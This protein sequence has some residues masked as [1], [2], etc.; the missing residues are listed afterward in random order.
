MIAVVKAQVS[1]TALNGRR[2]MDRDVAAEAQMV[3]RCMWIVIGWPCSLPRWPA[4]SR[5]S[6]CAGWSWPWRR[7]HYSRVFMTRAFLEAASSCR[8]RRRVCK[9][10]L[11]YMGMAWRTVVRAYIHT[12]APTHPHCKHGLRAALDNVPVWPY[13]V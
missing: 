9:D 4:V 10:V 13:R 6:I 11:W 8:A 2:Y 12:V 1:R 3:S 7:P 5:E